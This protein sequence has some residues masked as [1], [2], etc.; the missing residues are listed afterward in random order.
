MLVCSPY[1]R[2][3]DWK[4]VELGIAYRVSEIASIGTPIVNSVQPPFNVATLLTELKSLAHRPI[5]SI[6]VAA[7]PTSAKF[8][9][10]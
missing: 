10:A 1:W 5:A 7:D 8:D 9:P 2:I 4:F 3:V 6:F